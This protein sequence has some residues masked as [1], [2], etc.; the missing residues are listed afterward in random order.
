M[1]LRCAQIHKKTLCFRSSD[2]GFDQGTLIEKYS[3]NSFVEAIQ[4]ILDTL[5]MVKSIK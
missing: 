1:Q 5:E 4:A 3:I 2:A